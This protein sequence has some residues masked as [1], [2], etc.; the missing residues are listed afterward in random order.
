MA[1]GR[2]LSIPAA[3]DEV[4][5]RRAITRNDKQPLDLDRLA[6]REPLPA[7]PEVN[8]ARTPTGRRPVRPA[9]AEPGKPARPSPTIGFRS[10]PRARPGW[11]TVVPP[12]E[13]WNTAGGSL[14]NP[15]VERAWRISLRPR[16]RFGLVGAALLVLAAAWGLA[17]VPPAPTGLRV[18]RGYVELCRA[19]LFGLLLVVGISGAAAIASERQEGT[20]DALATSPLSDTDLVLGKAAGVLLPATL[21]ASLLIPVHLA[22][23]VAWE[24]PWG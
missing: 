6:S 21:L 9:T 13:R 15:I 14:L 16:V 17:Q 1:D 22:C 18:G 23:G 20:W 11:A 3:F 12:L 24:A 4:L 10:R 5:L 7:P 8:P 2:V 19:E